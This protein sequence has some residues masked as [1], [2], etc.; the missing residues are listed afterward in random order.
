MCEGEASKASHDGHG[1]R[2]SSEVMRKN[3]KEEGKYQLDRCDWNRTRGKKSGVHGKSCLPTGTPC[4]D[5]CGLGMVA[6]SG[7][8][9]SRYGSHDQLHHGVW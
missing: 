6:Q 2:G 7:C 1:A 4:G 9:Q 3:Q 8:S 5:S